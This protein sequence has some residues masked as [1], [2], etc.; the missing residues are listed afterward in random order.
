MTLLLDKL[1]SCHSGPRLHL[2]AR[3]LE[4]SNEGDTV[5]DTLEVIQGQLH[6]HSPESH[7]GAQEM[8][9]KLVKS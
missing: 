9:R 2:L 3:G 6:T 7:K 5:T 1:P 8:L 4:V